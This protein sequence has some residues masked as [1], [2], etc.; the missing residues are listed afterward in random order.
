[1]AELVNP[2]SFDL[3]KIDLYPTT[4][5]VLGVGGA[6]NNT[7]DRL[8]KRGLLNVETVAVNTDAQHLLSVQAH[9]KILIGKNL[10]AG[11]GTGGDPQIGEKAAE[12]SKNTLSTILEGTDLLFLTGGLGGGTGTGAIPVIGKLAREQGTLTVAVVTMPFSEEG[13]VRWE[14]A[15]VGLQ[16]IK[17][18]VDTVIVLRNDKLFSLYPDM[19]L[20]E[21]FQKGDEVLIHAL[22]GLSEMVLNR[23]VINLDFADIRSVMTAGPGAVIG[24]G[25]SS[26]ENRIEEAIRKAMTHPMMEMDISG[27]QSALVHVTGGT[28]LTLKE[29]RQIIQTIAQKLDPNAKI[30]WGVTIEKAMKKNIRVMLIASGLK[31]EPEIPFIHHVQAPEHVPEY[32]EP[33]AS[34]LS[35][36]G[37][38]PVPDNGKS[39]FDIKETILSS[40]EI[41][42]SNKPRKGNAQTS[43]VFYK[44]FEEEAASDLRQFNQAV[45]ELKMHPENHLALEQAIRAS[46][47]LHASA[48]MFGFDEIAQLL[49]AVYTIL[50]S[51]YSKEIQLNTPLLDSLTLAVE[52]VMDLVEKRADGHGET[53]YIVNRLLEL[54]N[55]QLKSVPSND[56]TEFLF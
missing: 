16:R 1:M 39:I 14:N 9:R 48:Q 13:I 21:A 40:D 55:E 37:P 6:G 19:P 30:I 52:M 38:R 49:N 18:A 20:L 50:T 36:A 4:I 25:E 11:L 17:K 23:G 24:L 34:L 43:L 44:I 54:K 8:Y 35:P 22:T 15:K 42:T 31:Q 10:T 27:A 12:E 5:R 46:K 2:S 41:P 3:D 53:G 29:A 32:T 7:I 33:L 51:V 47:F 56:N 28:D 26:S 45:Q